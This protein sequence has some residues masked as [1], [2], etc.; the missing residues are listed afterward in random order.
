MQHDSTAGSQVSS[1]VSDVGASLTGHS[2]LYQLARYTL[3]QYRG[4]SVLCRYSVPAAVAGPASRARLEN[5]VKTAI[6]KVI[7]RAPTLQVGISGDESSKPVFI[8]LG[9][10]D[11]NEHVAWTTV[12]NAADSEESVQTEVA[13]YLD[14][15]FFELGARPGWRVLVVHHA[16]SDSLDI[17]FVWNHPHGD[18]M[19]GKIFHQFL[20]EALHDVTQN[21]ID[22]VLGSFIL[23]FPD[24]STQFPPATESVVG[25]PVTPLFVL[26]EAWDDYKPPSL[27]PRKIEA[28]WAPIRTHPYKTR[29]LNLAIPN[30]ILSKVLAACHE[31][32]TTLTALLNVLAL[33][34][35]AAH[36]EEKKAPAFAS[37]TA[38]DQR[39][40]L[41]TH[42]SS[43]PWLDP[44][45]TIAN[46][47]SIMSHEFDAPLVAEIRFKLSASATSESLPED[48]LALLWSIAT[49]V[50]GEIATRLEKGMHNDQ[51]CLAK[52]VPNWRKQHLRDVKKPRKLSWFITNLGVFGEHPTGAAASDV[53]SESC[54]SVRRAQFTLSTEIPVAALL[55]GAASVKNGPLVIT[56][57]WQDT[58]V[59][60]SL[61]ETLVGDLERWLTQLGS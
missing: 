52:F 10:V 47:V 59:E 33:V 35:L 32:K 14:M 27:F 39:R 6:G 42:P 17:L 34:S 40:F 38:I 43:F 26:K 16:A 44:K 5:V 53:E 3:D 29:F 22:G 37:S 4:T 45:E 30:S 61:V 12:E 23:D 57:T 21:G 58:V 51:I 36:I 9:T 18:G 31:R 56:C 46:Y 2:E 24:P 19:S 11:L 41:P 20:L 60:A 50:R 7:S 54:W 15:R 49:R 8:K 55:I 48:M 13:K 1:C 25:L 28:S